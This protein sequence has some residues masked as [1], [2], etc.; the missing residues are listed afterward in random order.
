M[1]EYVVYVRTLANVYYDELA[2]LHSS[3]L[4][5]SLLFKRALS[6]KKSYPTGIYVC[7]YLRY[8]AIENMGDNSTK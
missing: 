2:N 3:G 1:G 7:V 4:K 6:I 5:G 8:F